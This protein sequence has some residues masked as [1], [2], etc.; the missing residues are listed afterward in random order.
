MSNSNVPRLFYVLAVLPLPLLWL[1]GVLFGD[2]RDYTD[3]VDRHPVN[4][5][6][7]MISG[8]LVMLSIVLVA[9]GLISWVVCLIRRKPLPKYFALHLTFALSTFLFIAIH[10]W[11]TGQL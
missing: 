4:Y 10:W 1:V 8:L 3:F 11:V 7:G 2:P 6:V 9:V 5:A